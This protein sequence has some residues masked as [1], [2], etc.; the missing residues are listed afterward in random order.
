[1]LNS[2]LKPTHRVVG[3]G[4]L[5]VT[6][7]KILRGEEPLDHKQQRSLNEAIQQVVLGEG[8][9]PS[10]SLDD[11]IKL[12]VKAFNYQVDKYIIKEIKK[13][14]FSQSKYKELKLDDVVKKRW[15]KKGKD[16]LYFPGDKA[17]NPHTGGIE[18][19]MNMKFK[20]N[21]NPKNTD[22]IIDTAI[23]SMYADPIGEDIEDYAESWREHF[24]DALSWENTE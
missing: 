6:R 7:N 23:G 16:T 1:M 18:D 22:L 8:E 2:N 10:L 21:S 24:V 19:Y 14:K 17:N 12:A 3:L 15:F 5:G 20:F 4:L 11:M 9:S 13:K